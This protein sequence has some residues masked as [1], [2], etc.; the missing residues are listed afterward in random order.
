M[1]LML[2]LRRQGQREQGR[3]GQGRENMGSHVRLLN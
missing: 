1:V 2:R 3:A